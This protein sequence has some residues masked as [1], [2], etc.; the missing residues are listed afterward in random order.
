MIRSSILLP[1]LWDGKEN[2]RIVVV[3]VIV[4]EEVNRDDEACQ[5]KGSASS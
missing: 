5:P 1:F 2:K 3:A 4:L